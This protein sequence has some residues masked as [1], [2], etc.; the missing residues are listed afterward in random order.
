MTAC[1][2]CKKLYDDVELMDIEK[3]DGEHAKLCHVCDAYLV[4]AEDYFSDPYNAA[5][6]RL[7]ASGWRD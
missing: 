6:E 5:Y 3:E 4:E 2:R 1:D 7:R